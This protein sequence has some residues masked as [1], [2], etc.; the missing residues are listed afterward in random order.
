ML[1][2]QYEPIDL[3]NHSFPGASPPY[4]KVEAVIKNNRKPL[5]TAAE[6]S[7]ILIAY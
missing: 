6:K 5:H 7:R 3:C 2:G 4:H 1:L